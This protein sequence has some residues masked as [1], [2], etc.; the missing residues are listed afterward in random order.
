MCVMN[1]ILLGNCAVELYE[2]CCL[3]VCFTL[4]YFKSYLYCGERCRENSG[5]L[6]SDPYFVYTGILLFF[7]LTVTSSSRFSFN[8]YF[9]YSMP[10]HHFLPV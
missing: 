10:F 6:F 2:R 3:F 9:Y 7:F 1:C 8:K 4:P 5:S